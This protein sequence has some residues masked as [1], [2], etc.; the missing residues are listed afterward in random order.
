MPASQAA[1]KTAN[2]TSSRN[3]S[4]S[5]AGSSH[6]ATTPAATEASTG[7]QITSPTSDSRNGVP[8]KQ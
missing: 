2:W 1:A 6:Q 5:A 3:P 7:R 8:R 4:A